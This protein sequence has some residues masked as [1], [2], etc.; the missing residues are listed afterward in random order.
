[1]KKPI[2]KLTRLQQISIKTKKGFTLIELM[3]VLAIVGILTAVALPY[4]QDYVD[5]SRYSELVAKTSRLVIDTELYAQT[6]SKIL[7]L[8]DL[9][10]SA[11]KIPAAV[12][13]TT[14]EHGLALV[15]GVITATWKDDGS[16]LDGI[17]YILTASDPAVS[18]MTWTVSGSCLPTFCTNPDD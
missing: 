4:Y 14:T 15:D 18:P 16:R 5:S 9:D 3:I 12:S 2:Q 6:S 17:T 7:A 10:S 8:D 11:G 1:M 13:V